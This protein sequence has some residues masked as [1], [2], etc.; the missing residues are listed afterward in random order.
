MSFL[1][2]CA[3]IFDCCAS[4]CPYVLCLDTRNIDAPAMVHLLV[5]SK[6]FASPS[7]V[8]SMSFDLRYIQSYL[9]HLLLELQAIEINTCQCGP[10]ALQL[11]SRGF[12]PCAPIAPTLAVDVKMLEFVQDLFIRMPPNKTAWCDTLEAFLGKRAYKL[13]TRV[14]FLFL[15]AY[16]FNILTMS[17]RT[18]YDDGSATHFN[19]IIHWLM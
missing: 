8:S 9:I 10:A 2:C 11:L 19:G 3:L 16:F 12:F 5:I 4:Q 7:S 14:C 15:T 18:H 1:R 13:T 17:S 6:L